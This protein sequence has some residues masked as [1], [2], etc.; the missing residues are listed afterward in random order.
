MVSEASR[1]QCPSGQSPSSLSPSRALVTTW[2]VSLLERTGGLL[3][4]SFMRRPGYN[5]WDSGGC[6][7]SLCSLVAA[8]GVLLEGENPSCCEGRSGSCKVAPAGRAGV[9]GA[10][11]LLLAQGPCLGAHS[12]SECGWFQSCPTCSPACERPLQTPA[13][14]AGVPRDRR[15]APCEEPTAQ[16]PRSKLFASS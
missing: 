16:V 13:K 10:F 11:H 8:L 3:C 7:K 4:P 15:H 1:G 9:L 5:Q 6:R 14:E 12:T 2:P